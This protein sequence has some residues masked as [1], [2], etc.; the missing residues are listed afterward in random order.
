MKIVM[1]VGCLVS[2]VRSLECGC[3]VKQV[4]GKVRPGWRKVLVLDDRGNGMDLVDAT[5]ALV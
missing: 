1:T 5:V 3:E 2:S 4:Y